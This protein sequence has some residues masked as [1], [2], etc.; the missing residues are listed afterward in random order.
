MDKREKMSLGEF[1]CRM[2]KGWGF[3]M[4]HEVIRIGRA[5]EKSLP[6]EDFNKEVK[7]LFSSFSE[8]WGPSSHYHYKWW[9][10]GYEPSAEG[11]LPPDMRDCI[12]GR[13]SA[14]YLVK[15]EGGFAVGFD[16]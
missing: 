13:S 11:K 5:L 16:Y 3:A 10:E 15:G 12:F 14:P 1:V 8:G 6:K 9:V 7:I 2:V 4:P